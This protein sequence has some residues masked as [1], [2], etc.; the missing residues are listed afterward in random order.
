ME[1]TNV[2][3]TIKELPR[4]EPFA[5]FR[6]VL[7]NGIGHVVEN[8]DAIAISDKA[9]HYFPPRAVGVHFNVNQIVAVE[10]NAGPSQ[11]RR[12]KAI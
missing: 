2:V 10:E 6:I 4:R 9:I 5:K 11:K 1:R 8:P 7:D 3:S 12:K